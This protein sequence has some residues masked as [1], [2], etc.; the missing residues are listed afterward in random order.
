MVNLKPASSHPLLFVWRHK[1]ISALKNFM[2]KE[3]DTLRKMIGL[4]CKKQH[5]SGNNPCSDCQALFNYACK[6]LDRCRFGAD[7]PTCGKCPVHCYRPNLRGKIKE[8]MRYAGP[9]MF[10]YHPL[11]AIRHIIRSRKKVPTNPS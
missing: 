5:H 1:I 3:K 9:R 2:D 8:I 4:Y 6:R 11:D 7:K 10:I